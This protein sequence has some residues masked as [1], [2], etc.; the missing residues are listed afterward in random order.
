MMATVPAT[1]RAFERKQLVFK[2][3][4]GLDNQGLDEL[5]AAAPSDASEDQTFY[6]DVKILGLVLGSFRR[7]ADLWRPRGCDVDSNPSRCTLDAI[8]G[9]LPYGLPRFSVFS[10]LIFVT[11]SVYR[12]RRFLDADDSRRIVLP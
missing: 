11:F 7:N 2:L 9:A 1:V 8:H 12:S 6:A 10:T 4:H 5:Q 3:T